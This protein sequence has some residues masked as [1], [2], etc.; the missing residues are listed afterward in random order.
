MTEAGCLFDPN[1][2]CVK[3]DLE[4]SPP[5]WSAMRAKKTPHP[6]PN[7]GSMVRTPC[8]QDR[9]AERA[10]GHKGQP[11]LR[12]SALVKRGELAKLPG[13]E[14]VEGDARFAPIRLH[15]LPDIHDCGAELGTRYGEPELLLDEAVADAITFR[16]VLSGYERS[17]LALQRDGAV[18]DNSSDRGVGR[19]LLHVVGPVVAHG[20]TSV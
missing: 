4:K 17:I 2:T 16:P 19:I 7:P 10:S 9:A 6:R 11:L 12:A 8:A 3:H 15:F 20:Y 18:S 5:R 14:A 13:E 1:Q